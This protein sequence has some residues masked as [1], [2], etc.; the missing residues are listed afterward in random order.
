Y[1]VNDAIIPQLLL[2]MGTY[3]IGLGYDVNI[4]SYRT[5]SKTFGGVEISLRYNK[6]ADALFTKRSEYRN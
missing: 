1:R 2:D 6:L 4:S 3:A 5:A